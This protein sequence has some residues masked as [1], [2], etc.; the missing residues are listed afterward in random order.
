M[1]GKIADINGDGQGAD[2]DDKLYD[3]EGLQLFTGICL[4]GRDELG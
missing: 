3:A 2:T 1:Y 4:R